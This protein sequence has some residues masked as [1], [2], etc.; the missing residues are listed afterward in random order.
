M[1]KNII[2]ENTIAKNHIISYLLTGVCPSSLEGDRNGIRNFKKKCLKFS[3]EEGELMHGDQGNKKRV[4][5]RSEDNRRVDI[6]KELHNLDHSRVR[7][8]YSRIS[9]LYV[10]ITLEDVKTVL[11]SCEGCLREAPPVVLPTITPIMSTRP[12]ERIVVDTIDLRRYSRDNRGYKYIFTFIDSFSKFG[13]SYPSKRKDAICFSS[14]F[15]KH[16]FTEGVWE[17]LHTD[18]G[19]EFVNNE[20]NEITN[21]YKIKHVR[22]RPYHPQSQGVVERF[23]K[24]IKRRLRATL[25]SN[26]NNWVDHLDRIVYYYNNNKHRATGIKPFVL[27]KAHDSSIGKKITELPQNMRENT[28]NRLTQYVE[29]YRREVA[30]LVGQE[31]S[32]GDY[33][34]VMKPYN[35][36]R[37]ALDSLYYEGRFKVVEISGT[38]VNVEGERI[39]NISTT[40]YN[41]K[42]Y[43]N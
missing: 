39:A 28:I 31:I 4:I 24:T 12:H 40:I 15:E 43:N 37:G 13:W 38:N 7:A 32:A 2:V 10:G 30:T 25:N 22:G 18:N 11:N 26:D 9:D 27:F 5:L 20:V 17:I 35:V 36:R 33:V 42:K 19:G 6:I 16:I 8:T 29:T 41:L 21:R 14:C 23:N 34:L 3:L 1:A